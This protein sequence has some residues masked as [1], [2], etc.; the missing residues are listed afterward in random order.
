MPDEMTFAARPFVC[1]A[2]GSWDDRLLARLRA[3]APT[4]LRQIHHGDLATLWASGRLE[5]WRS[6]DV[7]GHLW[8]PLARGGKPASWQAAAGERL[9][10]GLVVDRTSAVLH[11]C[12]LGVQELYVRRIGGGLYF[13]VRIDPLLALDDRPLRVDLRAWADILAIGGPLGDATPFVEVR[14]L[15]AATA[16]RASA[17]GRLERLSFEPS[18][19]TADPVDEPEPREVAELVAAQIPGG[20][21]AR[22]LVVTLSGG[23]DS[24]LLAALAARRRGRRPVAWTTSPDDGLDRDLT[25]APDVAAELGITHRTVVPGPEAWVEERSAVRQ[26]LQYLTW[27]HTWIMPLAR[28]LHRERALVLDG[29]AGDVLLKG[30][31]Y[32]TDEIREVTDPTAQ[33]SAFWGKLSS[34]FHTRAELFAPGVAARLAQLARESFDQVTGHLDG[35]PAALNLCQLLTRTARSIALNPLWLVGPEVP[36]HLPFIHPTVIHAT[37]RAPAD[38]A[39]GRAFYEKV[40]AAAGGDTLARLPSTHDPRPKGLR[41]QRPR[42]RSEQALTRIGETITAVDEVHALLGPELSTQV[43]S[44]QELDRRMAEWRPRVIVLWADLF[45]EWILRYRSRLSLSD[46]DV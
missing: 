44:P 10:A 22:R 27:R 29:F 36:V 21:S 31:S 40:L 43:K 23:W 6:G 4:R 41:R 33:R 34:G 19:L 17:G 42:F 16:W 28:T 20:W 46:W 30:S 5:R 37:L 1:G 39:R 18:W 25:L 38:D 13:S 3:A 14:R 7:K 8:W 26:R 32:V 2:I 35:H 24:R 12:G 9:A 15:E 11:T 45:A